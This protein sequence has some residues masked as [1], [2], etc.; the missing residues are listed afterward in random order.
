MGR[1]TRRIVGLLLFVALSFAGLTY[2][3]LESGDVVT[4]T[5]INAA[6]GSPRETRIWF[7]FE[8]DQLYLEAGNPAN[9][10]VQDLAKMTTL[11]LSGAGLDGAWEFSRMTGRESHLKIRSMMR[12]KYGWGDWWI[13]LVF[14]TSKTELLR[15]MRVGS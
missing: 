1:T 2:L 4:V 15:V 7:V 6:T 9:P 3:A 8:D 13:G 14:D 5:T 11:T 10:W 12:K